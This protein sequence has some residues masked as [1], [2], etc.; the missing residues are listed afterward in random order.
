MLLRAYCRGG[1]VADEEHDKGAMSSAAAQARNSIS[2]PVHCVLFR[3]SLLQGS[4]NPS[5][6]LADLGPTLVETELGYIMGVDISSKIADPD[7]ARLASQA[8]VAAFDVPTNL[9]ERMGGRYSATDFVASNC[10]NQTNIIVGSRFHPDDYNL[11]ELEIS[12]TLNGENIHETTG[13][14]SKGGQWQNLM[15]LIN[16]I[17]DKGHTI[18]EGDLILSG[19]LG[20]PIPA[21]T[22]TYT[23][24]YGELGTVEFDLK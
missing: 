10:G 12:L 22:G 9:G 14:V 21:K 18:H 19:S 23:A 17:I 11:D 3:P 16:Q 4:D 7:E 15:T 13:G 1:R 8:V 5:L 6:S 24:D 2:K 20:S